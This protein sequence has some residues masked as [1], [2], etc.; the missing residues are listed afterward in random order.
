MINEPQKI[1]NMINIF[2]VTVAM[3][4]K[5][6]VHIIYQYYQRM[7]YAHIVSYSMFHN[8]FVYVGHIFYVYYLFI[9]FILSHG[10][11]VHIENENI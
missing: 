6:C 11:S 3:V 1:F 10:G 8:R 5:C 4:W 9:F 2:N 7:Y